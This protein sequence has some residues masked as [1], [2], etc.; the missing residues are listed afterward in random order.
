MWVGRRAPYVAVGWLWFVVTL[1]PVIGIVQVGWQSIAD[2]YLYLPMI[3]PTVAVVWG[4]RRPAA[5]GAAGGG[6]A[7]AAVVVA[8]RP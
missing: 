5:A 2:R 4:V 8:L 1:G 7:A 3:G 6:G